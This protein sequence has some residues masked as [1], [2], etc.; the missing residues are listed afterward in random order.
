MPLEYE[1][2][3][4][5]F[6][7]VAET[8]TDNAVLQKEVLFRL[9]ERLDDEKSINPNLAPTHILE[10]GCG[11][12]WSL[13]SLQNIFINTKITA[14]DFSKSMLQKIPAV[15]NVKKILS[16]THELPLPDDS[17]DLIFSNMLLH[18]CNEATV[19]KECFRVLK[20][21]GLLIM[22][23]LG[24]TTLTEL[25]HA[26]H[27]VDNLAH[28]HDF[29]AL[30][31]LGDQL[32]SAGFEQVVVN[33]EI[34]TLTYENITSLLRDIKASGGRNVLE[35]RSKGLLSRNKF[36]QL[37][38]AYENFRENGRLPAGYEIIYLRAK[39]PD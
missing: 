13:S 21:G 3:R 1:A 2:I 15:N 39:K 14:L 35:G 29:P 31:N 4:K 17:V 11:P 32:L 37:S 16:D 30:H 20:K 33:A 36:N 19:M 5:S 27:S 8:Y 18:W 28:V 34:I 25:K 22:S 10:L 38:N 24:E 26:W 6:D 23:C 7:N 9:L 12:G